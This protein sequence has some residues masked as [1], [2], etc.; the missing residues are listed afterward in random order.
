MRSERYT[1]GRRALDADGKDTVC[2]Q[3]QP[4]RTPSRIND[5][6]LKVLRYAVV[7]LRWN[8]RTKMHFP[9]KFEPSNLGTLGSIRGGPIRSHVEPRHGTSV[10]ALQLK[11]I[12]SCIVPAVQLELQLLTLLRARLC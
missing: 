9:A 4:L 10:W 2:I 6:A 3:R 7:C 8:L 5:I 1:T 12:F 11:F